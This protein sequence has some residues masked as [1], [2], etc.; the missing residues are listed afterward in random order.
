MAVN[1]PK[2]TVVPSILNILFGTSFA[3]V[4]LLLL[5]GAYRKWD[6]LIDPPTEY[7]FIYSQSLVKLIL[8][9]TGVIWFTYLLA[10]LHL[11][12]GILVLLEIV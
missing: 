4:G 9:K 12:S 8:G 1:D 5:V 2:P 10:C 3:L 7:W 6:W 11:A